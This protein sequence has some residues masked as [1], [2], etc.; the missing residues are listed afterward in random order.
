M[1]VLVAAP[2]HPEAIEKLKQEGFEVVYK[3]YPS[4]EELIELVKDVDA[5]IVRSKPVVTKK[6]IDAAEKLKV[7]GRA[8]VGIDNID[9]EAAKAKGI[10]V[11]NTPGAPTRSVAELAIGLM[12]D[13]LR[14]IAFS[15]RKMREGKWPKKEALGH[16]LY[17]KTL[18]V[19]G[20]GR[21]G[22]EVARIAYYGFNMKILYYDVVRC[23]KEFEEELKMKYVDLD[24]LL[25]ESDIVTIH[26]PLVKETYHLIDENKLKL[27]KKTAILINTARGA[28]VDTNA[29]VKALKEGWIAGA[30]LDV[31]EEEPL[32]PDHPLRQ[33]DNVVLTP[34]IG[35][36][37][38]EAQERA[39]MQ[40]VEKIIEILKKKT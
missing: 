37:T 9:V 40:I 32:P 19:I 24:T 34:H 3:E 39:G 22:R 33:L 17:G 29:L 5:L 15:D 12:I 20:M 11:V 13:V 8:G 4:E 36:N 21:I 16:E 23:S 30:G 2:I 27:M 31:Y 18:G 14:K 7:I 1:K 38:W 25:K 35:A 26:V 6:V 28:V 10:E